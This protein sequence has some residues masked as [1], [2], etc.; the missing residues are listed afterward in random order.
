MYVNDFTVDYGPRGRAAVQ[1]LMDE[2]HRA[3]LLPARL[4][5]EFVAG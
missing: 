3:G 5:V 4:T 1:R 2:A